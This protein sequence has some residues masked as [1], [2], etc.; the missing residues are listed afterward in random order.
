MTDHA[1]GWS[2]QEKRVVLAAFLGWTLDAFDFFLVVFILKDIAEAFSTHIKAVTY[3]I[4]LTLMM[5]PG[6]ALLAGYLA[7]RL[8]RRPVL[9]ASVGLYALTNF[10]SAFAP[11][12]AVLL[13]LR[14]LFGLAMG[15]EW[16]VGASLALE[17]VAVQRRGV[18][19]GILQVG[20]PAG[21]LL[22][23]VCYF[24]FYDWIGWRGMFM[25][26]L[27]PALLVIYIRRHVPESPSWQRRSHILGPMVRH[28]PRF[29]YCVLLMALFN[30]FS[31]GSGDIYPTFLRQEHHMDSHAV[32]LM[33][34]LYN[35]GAVAGGF[36]GGMLSERIGRRLAIAAMAL[37]AAP[38][39]Y[40]WAFGEGFLTLAMGAVMVHFAVQGAWGVVPAH[41]N[42]LAP[43]EARA[44]FPGF[45]YQLGN[46]ISAATATWQV[47]LAARL[48][49]FDMALG[50]WMWVV[51]VALMTITL[52]G[53][54]AKGQPFRIDSKT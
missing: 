17:S 14:A 41:L 6:G 13:V 19:S 48:G 28:W 7:D 31:H 3:A 50:A 26:G 47:G 1:G 24:V 21:Y 43:P 8:G 34:I 29:V 4:T 39:V 20:Y 49:R 9:M 10:L 30:F 18:V 54:E 37:L 11:D 53:P 12:L 23:A 32:G 52:L 35:L 40:P 33:A 5:R 25:L 36:M 27:L 42:E 44:T 16:G 51:M 2:A 15:G 46:L 38:F 22:A 45:S